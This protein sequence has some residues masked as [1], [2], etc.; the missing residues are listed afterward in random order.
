MAM[1]DYIFH[2]RPKVLISSN[3]VKMNFSDERGKPSR[4]YLNTWKELGYKNI[5]KIVPLKYPPPNS[6]PH[7]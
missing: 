4:I 3:M 1:T 5:F 6:S 7:P 2:E